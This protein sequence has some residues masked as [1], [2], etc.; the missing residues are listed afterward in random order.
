MADRSGRQRWFIT[1]V[2]DSGGLSPL[3][4]TE[5]V[6]RQP[7][8]SPV[9]V[10]HAPPVPEAPM[11]RTSRCVCQA[12]N[13]RHLNVH[14]RD[15]Q[16]DAAGEEHGRLTKRRGEAELS[17]RFPFSSRI[18]LKRSVSG[19]FGRWHA[20]PTSGP[21]VWENSSSRTNQGGSDLSVCCARGEAGCV[22]RRWPVCGGVCP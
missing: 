5:M 3:C 4:K 9:T 7:R 10:R 8:G 18:S 12:L 15:R 6:H 2:P 17:P 21:F 14:S 11:T 22:A 16:I 13:H 1:I 19:S 20:P